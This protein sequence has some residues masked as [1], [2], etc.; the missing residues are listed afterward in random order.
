M[1]GSKWEASVGVGLGWSELRDGDAHP[2]PRFFGAAKGPQLRQ[3]QPGHE[4][5]H[6]LVLPEDQA[7]ATKTLI[8][9]L[10]WWLGGLGGGNRM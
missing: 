2:R 8:G 4:G 1:L 6:L 9:G 7:L 10:D 3:R 5:N